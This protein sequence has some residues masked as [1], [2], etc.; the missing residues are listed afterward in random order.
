ME[1]ILPFVR[2]PPAGKNNALFAKGSGRVIR[3]YGRDGGSKHFAADVITLLVMSQRDN[4]PT[5]CSDFH[6]KE[7]SMK[8]KTFFVVVVAILGQTDKRELFLHSTIETQL[9]HSCQTFA[10]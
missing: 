8:R 1:Q 2:R 4:S 10:E 3:I 6:L 9:K 7:S 5:V